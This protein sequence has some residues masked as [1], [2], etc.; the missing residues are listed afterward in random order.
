MRI[1]PMLNSA[2]F[3]PYRKVY[4][5][6]LR[7]DLEYTLLF[8]YLN[9]SDI[10]L[11]YEHYFGEYGV[12]ERNRALRYLNY[13]YNLEIQEFSDLFRPEK[14]QSK[15]IN[16]VRVRNRKNLKLAL[17][18]N[19]NY[20]MDTAKSL[21]KPT[22]I[23]ISF[24]G[25]DGVGKSSV[26]E[27]V[28]KEIK[29]KYRLESVVLKHRPRVLPI[30][31]SFKHGSIEKA[32]ELATE[33]VPQKEVKTSRFSGL[34]RFSYYYLDYLLG[35]LIVSVKY[36]SRGKV[37]IYDRYYFD[38]INH[39]EKSNLRLNKNVAKLFYRFI[40]KPKLNV[41]L[42]A[43]SEKIYERKQELDIDSI[44]RLNHGYRSLFKE[45][46]GKYKRSNYVIKANNDL[47]DTVDSILEEV[48][49]VA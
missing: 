35:S 5:P 17:K 16:Q 24:S 6:D 48:R 31:S 3:C 18:S 10:P 20:L 30:L 15:L 47:Q 12:N 29:D 7:F 45:L 38:F 49:K 4:I 14:T 42:H 28:K 46:S 23:T 27:Q 13:K 32:E 22:Q 2:R 21:I 43:P 9:N 44:E 26:I 19:I 34:V 8:Y 41:L 33:T 36:R 25:V 37:V 39:Q 40:A 1:E 11:R